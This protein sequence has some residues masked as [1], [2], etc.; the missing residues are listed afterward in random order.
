M[1]VDL[2]GQVMVLDVAAHDGEWQQ[3]AA[4]QIFSCLWVRASEYV[5]SA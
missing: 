3:L 1:H 5:A 2:S 4:S